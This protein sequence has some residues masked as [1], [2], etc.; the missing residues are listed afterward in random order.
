MRVQWADRALRDLED[1]LDF[2][3][4]DNP[5]AAQRL[6]EKVFRK[7]EQLR[8]FPAS[9][10]I[11]REVGEPVRAV[12]VKP[13]RLFYLPAEDVVTILAVY[14]EEADIDPAEILRDGP[15]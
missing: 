1:Q 10:P 6:Y 9:G 5:A 13:L 2:I 4:L 7:T 12:L 11:S 3:A 15:G 8:T 14:R